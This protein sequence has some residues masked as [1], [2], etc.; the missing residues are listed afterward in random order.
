MMGK[1]NTKMTS[2]ELH[3]RNCHA[4]LKNIAPLPYC[5]GINPILRDRLAAAKKD[6]D[7]NTAYADLYTRFFTIL[8]EPYIQADG[9]KVDIITD[10][11]NKLLQQK[12]QKP[13][14][15]GT[16]DAQIEALDTFI[17]SIYANDNHILESTHQSI[18]HLTKTHNPSRPSLEHQVRQ[19]L[20]YGKKAINRGPSPI[21]ENSFWRTTITTF[22][23]QFKPQHTTS[24]A[25]IRHYQ[26]QVPSYELPTEY[27]FGTQGQRH[28]WQV[29][30]SP[31]F[32]H[33][34]RVHK[35]RYSNAEHTITHVYFNNLS[36]D[37]KDIIGKKESN[38]T[39]KLEQIEKAHPNIAVITL[40]A[41]RALMSQAE[42]TKTLKT[43]K[44]KD[45]YAELFAIAS[46]TSKKNGIKDFYIS[47]RIKEMLFKDKPLNQLLTNSFER[48]G[49]QEQALMSPAERQAVWF[50]FLKYDLT[51]HILLSLKPKSINFT[52]KDAIDRG[53]VSSAYYNLMKSLDLK[54]PMTRDEFDRA[55]HAAP[56]LVKGRGM[57]SNLNLIW[58]ALDIYLQK[59]H[60]PKPDWLV[61]WRDLNC[62][63]ARVNDLLKRRIE[64][65]LGEIQTIQLPL[66]EK[67]KQDPLITQSVRILNDIK[68]QQLQGVSGKRLLLEIV[69][70]TSLLLQGQEMAENIKRYKELHNH[71]TIN[72]PTL[73]VIA[74]AMKVI[75]ATII[76]CLSLGFLGKKWYEDGIASASAGFFAGTRKH[77]QQGMHQLTEQL[78]KPVEV[79]NY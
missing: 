6:Y 43:L 30:I 72:H 76:R 59:E 34:L 79:N 62:P 39:A 70:R 55:L 1:Q 5:L 46:Q 21:E 26:Y 54:K 47:P 32:E 56:T 58:N 57:N 42:Y 16:I 11:R 40:P 61:E 23:H 18:Q 60:N 17:L 14:E 51:N 4:Y 29:R 20:N 75:I 71:L 22:G 2:S 8:E 3:N 52:C 36:R 50:H 12:I 68:Q 67:S 65:V 53:G 48:M 41:D 28:Q 19:S 44:Y 63:H 9:R 38:L 45:V 31:L 78:K 37:R 15:A 33:W 24:L 49:F 25:T 7:A 73:Q 35:E 77:L 10:T 27:R 74:S 13:Q 66:E 69:T 64:E